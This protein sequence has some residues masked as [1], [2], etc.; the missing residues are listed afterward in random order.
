M[1]TLFDPHRAGAIPLPNR[2][3]MAPMTRN[4]ADRDGVPTDLMARYYAQRAGA[5]LIV[6]ESV[7]ISPD[8]HGEAGA[9]G[10]HTAA[11]AAG[12]RT[13]TDAVH[14][15]GGRI[16]AQLVHTGRLA[17]PALLP[18]GAVPLA[19]S[20]VRARTETRTFDGLVPC[21]TPR[22]MTEEE[23]TGAVDAFAAAARRA[24]DAGFDGVE[25]QGANGNLIHQFLSGNANLRTD[26]YGGTPAGRI[27][28]ALETVRAVVAQTGPGRVGLRLSPGSDYGD[29]AEPDLPAVHGALLDAL[30]AEPLAYLHLIEGPDPAVA[31]LVRERWPATL[32][33]N[34]WTGDAPTDPL[35]AT[36][37]VATG[38]AD[39]VSFARMFAANPDLPERLRLG[40]PLNDPDPDTFHGGDAAGYTDY[41]RHRAAVV[42]V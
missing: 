22:E 27:R 15:A 11:Q 36:R 6:T 1:A 18:P 30:A 2:V 42:G 40:V 21:V 12:W 39:A 35:T 37:R 41:P 9:P 29:L 20:A 14:R 19:P 24:L 34:P 38:A 28:F 17:H 3:V 32:I 4:R 23:I 5:G 7:W 25:L 8:G 26:G 16:V 13:V 10:L 31:A 33:V